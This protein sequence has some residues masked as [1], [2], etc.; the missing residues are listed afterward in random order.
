VL[1]PVTTPALFTVATDGVPELHVPPVVEQ[2][3]AVVSPAHNVVTPVIA[4]GNAFTVMAIVLLH[5]GPAE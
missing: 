1:T 2:L 5:P 3:S 4:A